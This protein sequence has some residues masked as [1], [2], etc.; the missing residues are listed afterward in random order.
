MTPPSQGGE[1]GFKSRSGYV[2]S[3]V[4]WQRGLM[5]SVRS[6]TVHSGPGVQIPPSPRSWRFASREA[7]L[8]PGSVTNGVPGEVAERPNAPCWNYGDPLWS[9]GSNP[10]LSALGRISQVG[11]VTA[12]LKPAGA[13][14]SWEFEPPSYRVRSMCLWRNLA[15]APA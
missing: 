10:V 15:D 5:H 9:A 8:D 12:D 6:G 3:L 13:L 7:G 11:L 1:H 4:R 2:A 14:R